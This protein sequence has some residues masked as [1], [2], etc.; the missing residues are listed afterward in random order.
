READHREGCE[1]REQQHVRRLI[2]EEL[3]EGRRR[4]VEIVEPPRILVVG[5]LPE[6]RER[7][8]R[9]A[10]EQHG[11]RGRCGSTRETRTCRTASAPR[12]AGLCGEAARLT[13]AV[14]CSGGVR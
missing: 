8:E 14:H 1:G 4:L 9:R 5:S 10:D 12:G 7:R 6:S 13:C 3:S 2:A 11:L